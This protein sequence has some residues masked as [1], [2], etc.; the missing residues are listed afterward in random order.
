MAKP[1]NGGDPDFDNFDDDTVVD[2]HRPEGSLDV[3]LPGPKEEEFE[4]DVVDDTP[5][6][7][8][9]A[10]PLVD[11]VDEPTDEELATYSTKV[12]KRI[13]TLTH[14]R[15]DERRKREAIERE[16]AEL[17]GV[18]GNIQDE[19]KRLRAFAVDGTAVYVKAATEAAEA[20]VADAR[21]KLKEAK[22]AYDTDGEI[23]A[24]EALSD[25]KAE[26]LVAKNVRPPALQEPVADVRIAASTST[27]K[28]D[29]KTQ[30]WTA[31]NK[32]FNAEG[33]EDVTAY[34]LGLHKQ[35]TDSGIEPAT[36]EYFERIDARMQSKFPEL[37]ASKKAKREDENEGE[38]E[39][40]PKRKSSAVAAVN[41]S[42]AK[43][44]ITLTQSQ[45]ALCKK[46]GVT[47]QQYAAELMK[48]GD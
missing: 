40:P 17:L 32:W 31:R 48:Q 9:R 25:A 15:H 20:K 30:A 2:Q 1:R 10:R 29:P 43:K 36:D 37:Y 22:E 13:Q 11:E 16:Q 23:A 27:S 45:V 14:A 28:L 8:R 26:V 35:L 39:D 3:D 21:R 24:L 42:T 44:R 4:I 47:P 46:L 18:V 33:K 5:E 34:A 38:P 41:R 19:N 7:D 12:Q 6:S